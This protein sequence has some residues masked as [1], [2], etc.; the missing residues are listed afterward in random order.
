MLS[1]TGTIVVYGA[2]ECCLCDEALT[3]LAPLQ[4]ELGLAVR[5]V[6]IS[7]DAGLESQWREEIPVGFLNGRK[8]F[9]Y[10]VD[11]DLIRRR[12]AVDRRDQ[13]AQRR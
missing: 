7:G 1:E 13:S 5:Y 10:R 12:V 2:R 6:D 11:A 3:E 9:K 4:S 8:V